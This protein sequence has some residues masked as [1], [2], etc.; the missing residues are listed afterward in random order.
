LTFYHPRPSYEE[1]LR[2][3]HRL[4]S[5]SDFNPRPSY[6]ERLQRAQD[7]S[8]LWRYFNPRPSYEERLYDAIVQYPKAEFQSTPL[9]RGATIAGISWPSKGRISIHAPHTRS[10][11]DTA[12]SITSRKISI[13]APHTRSDPAK[14]QPQHPCADFNPRP[15]YEERLSTCTSLTSSRRNFNPRPSY[16]ER[17]L[18]RAHRARQAHIS[19][20][21]PHTRSDRRSA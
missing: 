11:R 10:D 12:E 6:E 15:S 17:R 21:A 8:S 7:C 19:I 9:I 13:H 14:R 5:C 4:T 18:Q 1:R 16:E 2:R 3:R 20:H